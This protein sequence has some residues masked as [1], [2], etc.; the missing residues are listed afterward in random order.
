METELAS[1]EINPKN[2]ILGLGHLPLWPWMMM[3]SCLPLVHSV[4]NNYCDF[5]RTSN[6]TSMACSCHQESGFDEGLRILELLF[7]SPGSLLTI[8]SSPPHAPSYTSSELLS[9]WEQLCLFHSLQE[10]LSPVLYIVSLIFSVH[11][12]NFCL[13]SKAF[14]LKSLP[15]SACT[16]CSSNDAAY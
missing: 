1:Q 16:Q 6:I 10:A 7:L 2:G 11:L 14:S 12:V 8:T 15:R 4:Y 3:T 9:I 5:Y 13:A